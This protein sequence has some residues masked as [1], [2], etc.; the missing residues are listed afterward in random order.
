MRFS[1]VGGGGDDRYWVESPGDTVV[2]MV[3]DGTD[4]VYS[5]INYTLP[6]QV[7][8]LRRALKQTRRELEAILALLK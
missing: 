3:G 4:T 8:N 7:E 6:D 2:E 1:L 5:L